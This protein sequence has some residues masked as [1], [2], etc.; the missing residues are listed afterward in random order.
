MHQRNSL[1]KDRFFTAAYFVITMAWAYPWHV[2]WFHELYQSWGTIT[3][4]RPIMPSGATAILIQGVVIGYLCPF[5]FKGGNPILQG[6]MFNLIIGLMTYTTM[7]FAFN[8]TM[9]E[10]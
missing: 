9:V 8:L 1:E 10:D 6:V 2:V 3:R 4:T 7:G 5:F